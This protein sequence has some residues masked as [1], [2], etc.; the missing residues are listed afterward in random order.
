MKTIFTISILLLSAAMTSIAQWSQ[1]GPYEMTITSIAVSANGTMYAGTTLNSGNYGAGLYKSTDNGESWATVNTGFPVYQGSLGFV[2]SVACKNDTV[3]INYLDPNNALQKI[4]RS[5]NG[6]SSWVQ[7]NSTASSTWSG[8]VAAPPTHILV[9]PNT[10]LSGLGR[11]VYRSING[12]QT[13]TLVKSANANY[14]LFF[15]AGNKIFVGGDSLFVSTD[16]GATWTFQSRNYGARVWGNA[17]TLFGTDIYSAQSNYFMKLARSTDDGK[18]WTD[19]VN[20]LP[21]PNTM[22]PTNM[23]FNDSKI[24]LVHTDGFYGYNIITSTNNGTTWDSIPQ[25]LNWY[26]RKSLSF[27]VVGANIFMGLSLNGI[28]KSTDNGTTWMTRSKGFPAALGIN[29]VLKDGTT[30]YLGANRYSF[31]KS[32]DNGNS[33]NQ[34]ANG[35]AGANF[36][37]L[38]MRGD[39]IYAG[40]NAK[41]FFKSTNKGNTWNRISTSTSDPG[42]VQGLAYW[43]GKFYAALSSAERLRVSSDGGVTWTISNTGLTQNSLGLRMFNNRL[44]YYSAAGLFMFTDTSKAWI[45]VSKDS[46]GNS[47]VNNVTAIGTRLFAGTGANYGVASF[48][49]YSDDNGIVW[50]KTKKAPYADAG[51][52]GVG[53]VTIGALGNNLFAVTGGLFLKT[54][55]FNSTDGGDSWTDLTGNIP[56]TYTVGLIK[57]VYQVGSEVF[58]PLFD[59][60]SYQYSMFRRTLTTLTSVK[61]AEGIIPSQVNLSQNYPNPFNPSTNIRFEISNPGFVSLKVF[62]ILGREVAA[63]VNEYK[64]AGSFSVNFEASKLSSGVYFYK[65]QAG[66]FISTKKMVFQK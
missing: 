4:Y 19:I 37:A 53:P 45:Q 43:N 44:F 20:T 35:A 21:S 15:Q 47:R 5:V 27:K 66:S 16:E 57:D 38:I 32:T 24:F 65:L 3:Y 41:G 13:W 26:D 23:F 11:A 49:Y 56:A 42:D 14:S 25:M 12:G 48:V 63:L 1:T 61:N 6:G 9:T 28:I 60:S 46:I 39:T 54:A 55:V 31:Y 17:T 10:V 58:L 50:R 29:Q 36:Q 52:L 40:T 51:I 22:T 64:P 30:L 7:V 34:Y 18:T 59:F 8:A 2:H 33:W 62:D